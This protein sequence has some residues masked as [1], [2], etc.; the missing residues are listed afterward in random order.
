ME[1]IDDSL[2]RTSVSNLKQFLNEAPNSSGIN[3]NTVSDWNN[4]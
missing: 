1:N 2:M 3:I 4:I